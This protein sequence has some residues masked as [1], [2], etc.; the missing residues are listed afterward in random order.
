MPVIAKKPL[1]I[2]EIPAQKGKTLDE[3]WLSRIVIQMPK[4]NK[5]IA[6]I[7][8]NYY[9]PK[10]GEVL[11]GDGIS[12]HVKDLPAAIQDIPE[13]KVAM[14]AILQAY[15]KLVNWVDEQENLHNQEITEETIEENIESEE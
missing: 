8:S 10:T 9:D 5:G 14:G 6:N 3:L 1:V 4:P 2:P 11:E 15:P 7:T 12:I 13:V